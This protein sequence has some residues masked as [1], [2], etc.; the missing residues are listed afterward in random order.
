MDSCL[1]QRLTYLFLLTTA[2]AS[3]IA[4]EPLNFGTNDNIVI[5][6]TLVN[7]K[8]SEKPVLIAKVTT[9]QI[10]GFPYK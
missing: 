1:S 4:P 6:P 5:Q 2:L 10:V 9:A 3:G 8:I 7:C